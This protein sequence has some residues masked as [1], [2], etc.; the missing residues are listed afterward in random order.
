ME[1]KAIQKTSR[2][3]RDSN[4]ELFRIITMIFI[5]A[6]HYVVNS[7]L[8]DITGPIQQNPLCLKSIFLLLFGAW[9][10]TGI[11]CF[12]FITGYFMC[13]SN[14]T[15]R[16]F[17]K[18]LTEI[19]F[20]RIV[21]YLIFLLFG[22]EHLGIK[23][24]ITL[25]FPISSVTDNFT[26]CYLLFFLCIPFL[27]ILISNL[28]EKMHQRLIVLLLFIYTGIG[29]IPFFS[30]RFNY[31]TWF[32]VLYIISSYVRLYPKL[33]FENTRFW[34]LMTFLSIT[35]AMLS[36]ISLTYIGEKYNRFLSYFF[37]AG[38]NKIL[39]VTSYFF[40]ADSNKILAVT[41]AF[42]S[43]MLFKNLK[44]NYSPIINLLGATTFGV[45]LI[46]ANSDVMREWLWKDTLQNITMYKSDYMFIHAIISVL[47]IF[48]VCSCID[49]IRIVFMERK[50]KR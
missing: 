36:V 42:S 31:V 28:S 39:A 26:G 37:V 32:C 16:K 8:M 18:L 50:I 21:I 34:L 6:H 20:Y 33:I 43:F 22:K 29:S 41:T 24:I 40:V 13:K 5:I 19:Y 4:L 10:K 23:R 48:T 2:G 30:V 47:E 9:G 17:M 15:L 14:I 12:V 1:E 46:H 11:N 35:L 44:I 3:G 49:V 25:L 27:N 38:S 45:L 7:G